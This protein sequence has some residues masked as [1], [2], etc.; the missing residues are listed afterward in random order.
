M[1]AGPAAEPDLR[2]HTVASLAMPD[3][4]LSHGENSVGIFFVSHQPVVAEINSAI[5]VALAVEPSSL[6]NVEHEAA[7]KTLELI[8]ATAPQFRPSRFCGAVL[9]AGALLIGAILTAQHNLPDISK[10]LMNSFIGFSGI[11]I[12][13]LAGEAQKFSSA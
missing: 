3:G 10:D 4:P 2:F 5:R 9:I 8:K 12:G 11:V 13:L 7:Q 1:A 6:P